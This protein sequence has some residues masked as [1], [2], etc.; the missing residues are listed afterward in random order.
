MANSPHTGNE[1]SVAAPQ[2]RIANVANV[3]D[4][5]NRQYSLE[6]NLVTDDMLEWLEQWL[7]RACYLEAQSE[8]L[9]PVMT[10]RIGANVAAALREA[11]DRLR[12]V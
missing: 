7:G 2:R 10:R 1:V 6:R 12:S 4:R 5:G 11:A 8:N 3:A 9:D